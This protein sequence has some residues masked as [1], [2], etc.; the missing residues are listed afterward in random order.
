MLLAFPLISETNHT[1]N[2]WPCTDLCNRWGWFHPN[3]DAGCICICV[4][5][6]SKASTDQAIEK[7]VNKRNPGPAWPEFQVPTVLILGK[8]LSG[9][10]PIY[11]HSLL[12]FTLTLGQK[13]LD[14]WLLAGF[15]LSGYYSV[16]SFVMQGAGMPCN[17]KPTPI[18]IPHDNI[19]L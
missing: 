11:K 12:L 14:F 17:I 2:R 9:C 5:C 19:T 13:Q 16:D 10:L 1:L 7:Y 18:K 8:Q 6:F 15:W 4:K 3:I